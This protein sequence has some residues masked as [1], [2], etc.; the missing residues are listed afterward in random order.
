MNNNL[1]SPLLTKGDLGGLFVPN[2]NY[3]K[4]NG[5]L[6]MQEWQDSI[7][8]QVLYYIIIK[9]VLRLC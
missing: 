4:R 1:Y 7:K 2:L 8:L 6:P 3:Y 5:F 9:E